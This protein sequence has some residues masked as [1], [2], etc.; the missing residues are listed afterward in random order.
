MSSHDDKH[1]LQY[2]T[3][4]SGNRS[5]II[6][7]INQFEE[8]SDKIDQLTKQIDILQKEGSVQEVTRQNKEPEK[9]QKIEVETKP[10]IKP[11]KRV[12]KDKQ[13]ENLSYIP[14]LP[15]HFVEN[16]SIFQA[17]KTNLVA[18]VSNENRAPI[19]LQGNNGI[20]KTMM[21]AALARDTEIQHA[22]PG[23]IFWLRLGFD[24]D[25][26]NRQMI[27]IQALDQNATPDFIDLETGTNELRQLCTDRLCLIILDDVLDAQHILA[28]NLLGEY[29]KIMITSSESSIL[30]VVQC[31]MTETAQAYELP[32]FTEEEAIKFFSLCMNDPQQNQKNL[33]TNIVRACDYL[34]LAIKLMANIAGKLP[35]S[36]FEYLLERFQADEYE[37]PENYS[38]TLMQALQLNV[39]ELGEPADYYFALSVFGDYSRIPQSVVLMLWHY[40]YHLTDNEAI[41]FIDE[42]AEKGLLQIEKTASERYLIL[43]SFQRAYLFADAE[44]DKLH[45]HLLAAYRLHCEQHGWITG[46]KDGY[47]FENLCMHLHYAKRDNEVKSLLLDFNWIQA[48]LQATSI[49]AVLNDYDLIENKDIEAF[50]NILS[51]AAVVLG[52][53]KE[54]LPVQLLERLWC[55]DAL[56]KNNEIQS[57]INQAQEEAPTW[58]W[59][60][61]FPELNQ[62]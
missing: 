30:E 14:S 43:H 59:E 29:H 3:D 21:A 47:F 16:P 38:R 4:E 50:K 44:L 35:P 49:Q 42:L 61:D 34:P 11:Q 10:K 31:I 19:V 36:E 54:E 33:Y 53:H 5:A 2:I 55:N 23:G 26:L 52:M 28:F 12:V 32:R 9:P 48:K 41:D 7:S 22:F 57:L 62:K 27:L 6:L 37:F 46:P 24:V 60:A 18:D 1:V 40:L 20:G 51:E 58:R 45:D 25:L 13:F 8:M 39:E 15:K 56:R 17:I